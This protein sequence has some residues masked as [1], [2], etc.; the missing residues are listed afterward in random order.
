MDYSILTDENYG[1]I[2]NKISNNYKNYIFNLTKE[3]DDNF[4]YYICPDFSASDYDQLTDQ[5]NIDSSSIEPCIKERFST[6]LNYSKYNF[7]VVK[8][9]TEVSNSRKFPELFNSLFDDINYNNILDSKEIIEIDDIINNKNFLFI[10]NKT[11]NKSKKIEDEFLSMINETF[12][13]FGNKFLFNTKEL[14]NNF[15]EFMDS[16]KVILNNKNTMYNNNISEINNN[17]L[18]SINNSLAN[19]NST[20]YDSLSV[21]NISEY[22]YYS[23]EYDNYKKYFDDSFSLLEDSFNNYITKIKG[24]KDNNLFY[25]IPKLYLNDIFREKRKII[26]AIIS[27]YSNNYDF[28]SIGFKYNLS[29]YFDS[30]LK[31]YYIYYELNNSYDYFELIQNNKDIYIE[32]ILKQISDI[33]KI[34]NNKYNIIVEE[35]MKYSKSGSNYVEKNYINNIKLNISKCLKTLSNFKITIKNYLNDTNITE[36]DGYIINNCTSEEII[37]ALI[38]NNESNFCLNVSEINISLYYKELNKIS[39]CQ[40]NNY[41]NYTYIIYEG[42]KEDNK[43]NLDQ[44]MFNII[45]TVNSNIIDENYLNRYVHNYFIKNTSLDINIIDYKNYFED[46]QDFNLYIKNLREPEYQ[47]LMKEYFY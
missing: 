34:A 17:I 47:S 24:L 15:W 5:I 3:I 20:L 33:K 43:Y 22:D 44:N 12:E 32:N 42:F 4:T 39:E 31:K 13:D 2:T 26:E 28:D 29:N 18:E 8:F 19:F 27:E 41:Y 40:S 30:Y 45:K 23:I 37:E 38:N 6:K 1:N 25:S 21:I 9:R 7:N 14:T 36:T 35:F 10:Y 11:K 16:Y 46:I